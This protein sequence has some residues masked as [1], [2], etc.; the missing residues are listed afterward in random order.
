MARVDES[1]AQ[2][3]FPVE[4]P[5]PQD[6][7][8]YRRLLDW[9]AQQ[10][11]AVGR[12][13]QRAGMTMPET[14]S[15][16]F[17]G[18]AADIEAGLAHVQRG[19]ADYARQPITERGLPNVRGMAGGVAKTGLGVGRLVG[20]GPS[21]LAKG[22]TEWPVTVGEELTGQ[23]R[24]RGVEAAR[25]IVE[26]FVAA[27]VPV[28]LGAGP[29]FRGGTLPMR[30]QAGYVRM[31]RSGRTGLPTRVEA[32]PGPPQ[33]ALPPG[34]SEAP[35]TLYA[36]LSGR[37]GGPL[38]VDYFGGMGE[39]AHR[40][41]E[42]TVGQARGPGIA[43][44]REIMN[45]L[46]NL[47]AEGG[48]TGVAF[49]PLSSGST[50]ESEQLARA[51]GLGTRGLDPRA[52][53]RLRLNEAYIGAKAV[54]TTGGYEIPF[55]ETLPP[56]PPWYEAGPPIDPSQ[57]VRTPEAAAQ[58]RRQ[59][60]DEAEWLAREMADLRR[61]GTDP[62][63]IRSLA[64]G[65]LEARRRQQP[66][67]TAGGAALADLQQA[68]REQYPQAQMSEST[69]PYLMQEY[70]Q[71]YGH[72]PTTPDQLR[73]F[74]LDQRYTDETAMA[75]ML[76]PRAPGGP[77]GAGAPSAASTMGA[78]H[79]SPAGQA[80]R[81][82]PPTAPRPYVPPQPSQARVAGGQRGAE[83]RREAERADVLR[84]RIRRGVAPANV[85]PGS[86]T[87]PGEEALL[88]R[89]QERWGGRMAEAETQAQ[90]R[91]ERQAG[92]GE[93]F[94]GT[95]PTRAARAEPAPRRRAQS[96]NAAE[97]R[98]REA[99]QA[100]PEEQA[101]RTLE[102]QAARSPNPGYTLQGVTEPQYRPASP[103][104]FEH[105]LPHQ[106]AVVDDLMTQYEQRY[107]RTPRLSELS[108]LAT[109]RGLV[110][111]SDEFYTTYVRGFE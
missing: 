7:T 45:E 78:Q 95:E 81:G 63:A 86:L 42:A 26:P 66:A 18:G 35:P 76:G 11:H 110:R 55:P 12:G 46:V 30:N 32:G 4:R 29:V 23:T 10:G 59:M 99:F 68:I 8:V 25:A 43:E 52:E 31:S 60:L 16:E 9:L 22:E 83:A 13:V 17:T 3:V 73:Q 34:Q 98:A 72:D 106:R 74:A 44:G 28:T 104:D 41:R 21:A 6:P 56:K 108:D 1:Y 54:P 93:L 94:R 2:H 85:P 33:R 82:N 57:R 92:Q 101:R 75:R 100:D 14:F 96:L 67:S 61:Q 62:A 19:A 50:R 88:R 49:Y 77:A 58:Y 24:S 111:D 103:M 102:Q 47:G 27:T 53:G 107:G 51:A 70:R 71:H 48:Y 39:T 65:S 40:A 97:A 38:H 36:D 84:G 79:G 90:R 89:V 15:R 64:E 105:L 5:P 87:T 91:A 80:A 69:L 109:D 37:P 20:A